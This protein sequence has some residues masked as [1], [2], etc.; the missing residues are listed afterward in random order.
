MLE[1]HALPAIY[2]DGLA[3]TTHPVDVVVVKGF[4]RFTLNGKEQVHAVDLITRGESFGNAPMT[5]H[6]PSG[7][8]LEFDKT[9]C[10]NTLCACGVLRAGWFE[11]ALKKP[12][13]WLGLTALAT[14]LATLLS[15]QGL[16]VLSK[17]IA[18]AIPQTTISTWAQGVLP[19][20]D[21][22]VFEP[23]ALSDLAKSKYKAELAK[24]L[25][26]RP[27]LA[28]HARLEFRSSQLGPNAFALPDGTIVLSDELLGK[29][30]PE[31]IPGVLAHELGHIAQRHT[32][33]H[34]L[35]NAVVGTLIATFSGDVSI[36][37]STVGMQLVAQH[38][39]RE[40]EREADLFA[41]DLFIEQGRDLATLE[42][43]HQQLATL[44]GGV[45]GK[46]SYF[47]SH[48]G[49]EERL[50]MIRKNSRG[51]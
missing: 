33:R 4:L 51:F 8:I 41:I 5:L 35:Q 39:S 19:T 46:S 11:T 22:H 32:S 44:G 30:P 12:V 31:T 3:L 26:S 42:L 6:L 18:F 45:S 38:H 7:A 20:L 50:E 40:F 24:L 13:R 9:N 29:L 37:V 36:F 48:P 49:A 14:G 1:P 15:L 17:W 43:L 27:G 34:L 25:E 21:G 47:D 23:S 10:E 28:Q 2:R 16:P